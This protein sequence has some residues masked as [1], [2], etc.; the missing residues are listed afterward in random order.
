MSGTGGGGDG[1]WIEGTRGEG[2]EEGGGEDMSGFE[3]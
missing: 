1:R 3:G 2:P